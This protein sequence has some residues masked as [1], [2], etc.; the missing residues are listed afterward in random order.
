[1]ILTHILDAHDPAAALRAAAEVFPGPVE[2]AEPEM[3]VH[4]GTDR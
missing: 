2:L 4:I 3:V 1:L